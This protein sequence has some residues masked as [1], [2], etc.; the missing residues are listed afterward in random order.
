MMAK[1]NIEYAPS[2][3]SVSIT[4]S[5]TMKAMRSPHW[6]TEFHIESAVVLV[7]S[8]YWEVVWVLE[9]IYI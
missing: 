8:K 9:N 1:N 4:I 6:E 2:I 5:V 3:E 7:E